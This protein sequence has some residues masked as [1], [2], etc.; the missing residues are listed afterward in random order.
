MSIDLYLKDL[1]PVELNKFWI[2][3]LNIIFRNH[4]FCIKRFNIYF[5]LS[6]KIDLIN[7]YFLACFYVDIFIV[8]CI[9]LKDTEL[10]LTV[11]P[12]FLYNPR[13]VFSL[14]IGK[15]FFGVINFKKFV[16]C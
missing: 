14:K 9:L 15:S 2:F 16:N 4:Q 1:N 13:A 12:S 11:G 10:N 7:Q 8:V 3:L 6:L 5:G